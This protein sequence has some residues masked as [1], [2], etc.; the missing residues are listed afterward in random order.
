MRKRPERIFIFWGIAKMKENDKYS[1]RV[2]TEYE[3]LKK[4]FEENSPDRVDLL[5][6]LF[7]EAARLKTELDR[8]AEIIT[9]CGGRVRYNPMNPTQQKII[10]AVKDLEKIRAC[11]SNIMFKLNKALGGT[12]DEE[13]DGLDKYQ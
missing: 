6:G 10:P 1:E 5:D 3:R 9:L 4:I 2:S 11:Y 8:A 7:M 12:D 13:D